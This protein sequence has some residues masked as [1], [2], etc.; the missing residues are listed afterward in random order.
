MEIGVHPGRKTQDSD[1]GAERKQEGTDRR[2]AAE[3]RCHVCPL[4]LTLGSYT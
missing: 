1:E 4:S 3:N 2:Q